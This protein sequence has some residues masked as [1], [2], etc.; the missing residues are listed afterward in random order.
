MSWCVMC[1]YTHMHVHKCLCLN[2]HVCI[3]S[4][5]DLYNQICVQ[6]NISLQEGLEDAP[7]SS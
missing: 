3:W 7:E 2:T 1:I 4:H 5:L 6:M